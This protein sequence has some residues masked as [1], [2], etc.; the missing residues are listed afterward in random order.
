MVELFYSTQCQQSQMQATLIFSCSLDELSGKCLDITPFAT[1]ERYRFFA[2]DSVLE[3]SRLDIYEC[4]ELPQPLRHYPPGHGNFHSQASYGAVSYPWK[5]VQDTPAGRGRYSTYYDYTFSVK[6]A[7][8]GDP[9][10]IQTLRD[11]AWSARNL[12]KTGLDYTQN[13]R[14]NGVRFI[15][16]DRLSMMQ[17]SKF[18]K[19]WQIKRMFDIYKN[20]SCIILPGGLRRLAKVHEQTSWIDRAWTLQEAIAPNA[21]DVYVL[22]N[23]GYRPFV[24]LRGCDMVNRTCHVCV[25]R[26]GRRRVLCHLSRIVSGHVR[27]DPFGWRAIQVSQLYAPL[28]GHVDITERAWRSSMMRTSSRPVDTIFSIMRFHEVTLDPLKFKTDDRIGATIAF[29]QGRAGDLDW[30]YATFFLPPSPEYSI[31]PLLPKTSVSGQAMWSTPDRS[32]INVVDFC[33]SQSPQL[34]FLDLM[35]NDSKALASLD[36]TGY[37][38]VNTVIYPLLRYKLVKGR[39]KAKLI[40]NTRHLIWKDQY[41]NMLLTLDDVQGFQ[42]EFVTNPDSQP[43]AYA[44]EFGWCRLSEIMKSVF[45]IIQSDGSDKFK[46]ISSAIAHFP[47]YFRFLG[48]GLLEVH[49][50]LH[51]HRGR[52]GDK[53]TRVRLGGPKV[54]QRRR[55]Q[56]HASAEY[57]L[58]PCE[59]C[60]WS[61]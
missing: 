44:V 33:S 25:V 15:W 21:H 24:S 18:D 6:G 56:R 61:C 19:A 36:D 20:S 1:P 2:V 27:R 38:H 43:E 45:V 4:E 3:S 42:W 60:G 9:I 22:W 50:T 40:P 47:K 51:H 52:L 5:G 55:C 10:S 17:T 34:T 35:H 12:Q 53:P 46:R 30:F 54:Y 7:E 29:F 13:C 37:L 31:F 41:F 11:I 8:D 48:G 59:E 14:Y 28:R 49:E 23:P 39:S 32:E 57:L 26:E 16:L 58:D